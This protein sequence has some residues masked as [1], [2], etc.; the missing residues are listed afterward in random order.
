[1]RPLAAS[2]L[3]ALLAA[4]P[5][6]A[7]AQE[8]SSYGA[9]GVPIVTPLRFTPLFGEPTGPG[10]LLPPS[11]AVLPLRLSLQGDAFPLAGALGGSGCASREEASGNTQ[12][13]F[14]IQRQ[15]YLAL[16]PHLVLHGFSR[17]GCPLD[18]GM[19]GGFT[20]SLPL[21]QDLWLV[22]SAGVFSV[23]NAP[24]PTRLHTDARIDLVLPKT[25]HAWAV[26]VGRRG[27]T[28]SGKW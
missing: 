27:L 11:L 24:T 17:L 25:D 18:A 6:S 26:G 2:L 10:G 23:P 16:T 8:P 21:R 15:T 9:A 19:G 1:M 3:G 4:L 13:G 20:Y 14:P 7:S 22:A 28:F 12:W 5:L